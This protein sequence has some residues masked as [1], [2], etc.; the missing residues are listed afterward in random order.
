MGATGIFAVQNVEFER[1]D[2]PSSSRR[3]RGPRLPPPR[4]AHS[5][6]DK[7]ILMADNI[8]VGF[9]ADT[10]RLEAGVALAQSKLRDFTAQTRAAADAMRDA[11]ANATDEMRAALERLAGQTAAARAEMEALRDSARPAAQGMAAAG[12]AIERMGAPLRNVTGMIGKFGELFAVA[13]GG[14]K[15]LEEVKRLGQFGEQLVKLHE[16]TEVAVETLAGWQ[17][18]AGQVG[19]SADTVG[20]SLT[21]LGRSIQAALTTPTS[22]AA[23]AFRLLGMS[24]EYLRQNGNDYVAVL[25]RMADAFHDHE[26]GAQADAI[27]MATL[28][29]G[30]AELIPFLRQGSAAIEAMVARDKE[31]LGVTGKTAA[32]LAANA[33]AAGDFAEAMKGLELH[34]TPAIN[35]LTKLIEL[36]TRA[37]SAFSGWFGTSNAAAITTYREQ[38]ASLTADLAALQAKAAGESGLKRWFDD[39]SIKHLQA[40]IDIV[41]KKLTTLGASAQAITIPGAPA[42]SGAAAPAGGGAGTGS[43][44]SALPTFGNLDQAANDVAL[45]RAKLAEL[46]ASLEEVGATQTQILGRELQAWAQ[47]RN[48]AGLT[49]QEKTEVEQAYQEARAEFARQETADAIRTANEETAVRTAAYRK[50]IEVARQGAETIKRLNEEAVRWNEEQAKQSARAWNAGFD[51]I[52]AAARTVLQDVMTRHE[53]LAQAGKQAIDKLVLAWIDGLAQIMLKITAF[54]ALRAVS[55]LGGFVG[56]L[57]GQ[58]AAA[59]GGQGA[60]APTATAPGTAAT[61]LAALLPQGLSQLLGVGGGSGGGTQSLTDAVTAN[62]TATQ[63]NTSGLLGMVSNL[64]GLLGGAGKIF[65]SIGGLFGGG[66][67]SMLGS[68]GSLASLFSFDVGTMAV[69]HDMMAL[70]HQGEMIIPADPAGMLRGG[71]LSLGAGSSGAGAPTIAP[72]MGFNITALDSRSVAQL[73]NSPQVSRAITQMVQRTLAM[74]PSLQGAY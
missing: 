45:F 57:A 24:Q 28:G 32:D 64:T 1:G 36:S 25:M 16:Q 55:G 71:Q 27:A 72:N 39:Q 13:F 46:K 34:L 6:H 4:P 37:A 65:G 41:Q 7:A 69:P 33:S 52:G 29:R 20:T 11:G 70:V 58:G 56:G 26:A 17:Y 43:A 9:S 49:A 67:G 62:T 31:L 63:G 66:G 61:G 54:E 15:M 47:E 14:A 12:E 30:G 5:L 53:T 74:S 19:V 48:A 3:V 59:I 35:A 23:S 44:G 68:L 60:V 21:R 8:S 10:A 73:F 38:L 40:Q 18:A 42:A 22:Q 51:A 50:Q 2:N